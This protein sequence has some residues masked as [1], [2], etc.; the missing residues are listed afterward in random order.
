MGPFPHT[1][2][3]ACESYLSVAAI[4]ADKEDIDLAPLWAGVLC[5]CNAEVFETHLLK[6]L[7]G[8][9]R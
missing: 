1:W 8:T 5:L 7:H 4:K 6:M 2:N 9:A 3:A